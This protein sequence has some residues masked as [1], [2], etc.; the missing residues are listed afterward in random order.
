MTTAVD[1]EASHTLAA[2]L[3]AAAQIGAVPG[4]GISRFAWTPELAEVTRRVGRELERLGLVVETDTAGNMIARWPAPAGKAVMAASHL[5]T[6]PRGGPLDGVLG[7]LGAVEAVRILRREGFEP[8]RPIWIGAFMD[9]EGGRFGTALFGSRAFCGQDVSASLDAQDAAGVSM[10][11]AMAAQGFDAERVHEAARVDEVGAYVELHIE[12][13]PVLDSQG[14]RLGVVEAICG[15]LGYRVTVHGEAN[16]A[17]TTPSGLR[18]DALVGASRIVLALRERAA[19]RPDLSA[20]VGRIRALPGATNV[21]PGRCEFTVDLR[22]AAAEAFESAREWFEEMVA[23]VSAEE[24]LE[25]TVECDYAVQP[26]PMAPEVIEAVAAAAVA[27][28]IEPVRMASGAGH[29]AMNVGLHAPAGMIFVPSRGGISHSPEEWTDPADCEL[30]ARV[31]A[32]TLRQL[33]S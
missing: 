16:H 21:I 4:G 23:T 25:A 5:D 1:T 14:D 17:G 28:G 33:A 18:R 10:R 9:E 31:L 7:V 12:Q 20:T 30:G 11:D 24:R 29:D 3:E 13:G 15:V 6:V 8:A 32:S 22:A 2:D 19:S 26:T 27:E